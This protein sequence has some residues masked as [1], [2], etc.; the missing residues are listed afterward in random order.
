MLFTHTHAQKKETKVFMIMR[1][2]LGADACGTPRETDD[3]MR[4]ASTGGSSVFR[5]FSQRE[6][7]QPSLVTN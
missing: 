4:N 7:R 5:I 3:K 6:I 1:V 2:L